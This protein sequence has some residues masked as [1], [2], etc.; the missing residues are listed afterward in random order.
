MQRMNGTRS[1]RSHDFPALQPKLL[2]NWSLTPNTVTCVS[3]GIQKLPYDSI[4]FTP[5]K[6]KAEVTTSRHDIFILHHH[7]T[8]P[9]EMILKYI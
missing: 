6:Q 1:H 2:L 9:S 7:D 5:E 4:S 8:T 3:I